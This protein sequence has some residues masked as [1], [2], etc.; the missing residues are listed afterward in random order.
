MCVRIWCFPT[1]AHLH[2]WLNCRLTYIF[3]K[4]IVKKRYLTLKNRYINK[5][6]TELNNVMPHY[7][8]ICHLKSYEKKQQ[9]KQ[10]QKF[11]GKNSYLNSKTPSNNVKLQSDKTL[12]KQIFFPNYK[13][14]R[15]FP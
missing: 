8:E 14:D 15:I 11:H 3:E 5:L 12:T 2:F 10:K 6:I 13:A 1:H 7:N 9:Q 4:E